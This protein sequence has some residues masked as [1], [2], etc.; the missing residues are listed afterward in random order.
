MHFAGAR[1]RRLRTRR[2]EAIDPSRRPRMSD[3]EAP[4]YNLALVGAS[5]L[6]GKEVKSLLEERGFPV[7]RL[8][9]LDVEEVKGQLTEFGEEPM[10]IQPVSRDSFENM[11]F[12][13]F[14]SSPSVTEA[15]WQMAEE[16]G[17]EIIDLSYF[18]ETHPRAC[19]RAPLLGSLRE[20]KGGLS[21]MQASESRLS[22]SAH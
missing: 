8:V 19:L 9:L 4:Q 7:G 13:L 5:T 17:C 21:G 11:T 15:Y 3:S 14:A 16:C 12:A 2:G 20:E 6:K 10:I 1:P 18:L 22:V